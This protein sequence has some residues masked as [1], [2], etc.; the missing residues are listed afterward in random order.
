MKQTTAEPGVDRGP[1]AE[2]PRQGVQ[3]AA[4]LQ[5]VQD[6]VDEVD[7]RNPHVPALNR[8]TGVDVG[9]LFCCDPFHDCSP[10]EF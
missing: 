3:L 5:D 9:V 2:V 7:I 1:V 8:Q 6:R 10:L 4:V